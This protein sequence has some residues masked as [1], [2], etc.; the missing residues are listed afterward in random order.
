MTIDDFDAFH[1]AYMG[2][3]LWTCTDEFD[4]PLDA[5]Y[6]ISDIVQASQ[7]DMKEDCKQFIEGNLVNLATLDAE[8]CGH[9]FWL[10][11]CGHGAGYFDRGYG[12]IGD[13]L[14]AA[15]RVWGSSDLYVGDDGELYIS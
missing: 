10:S 7:D 11:R 2:C 3:A 9:D 6:E 13:D 1:K 8:Q 4:Q 12:K 5:V 15:A 14:Q